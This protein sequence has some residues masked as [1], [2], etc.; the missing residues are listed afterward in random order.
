MCFL[1]TSRRGYNFGREGREEFF[2]NN[3][4]QKYIDAVSSYIPAVYNDGTMM[5]LPK[6]HFV[7]LLL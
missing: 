3:W 1:F 4:D 6:L 7:E 2:M 5:F